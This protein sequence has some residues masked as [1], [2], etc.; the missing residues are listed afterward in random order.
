MQKSHQIGAENIVGPKEDGEETLEN[1]GDRKRDED[2]VYSTL[3]ILSEGKDNGYP[4]LEDIPIQG[5]SLD[6]GIPILNA[7]ST[8]C[9]PL[10]GPLKLGEKTTP[11]FVKD[12]FQNLSQNTKL[13][14]DNLNQLRN[15]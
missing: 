15:G 12:T 10:S 7:T 4:G 14:S 11:D 3:K 5:L 6:I 1:V 9:S 13:L 8:E 2:F